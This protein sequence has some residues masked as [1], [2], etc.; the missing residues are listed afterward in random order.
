[1]QPLNRAPLIDLNTP[2]SHS[3]SNI[4]SGRSAKPIQEKEVIPTIQDMTGADN[5]SDAGHLPPNN[6]V[7]LQGRM[8]P[9]SDKTS[10]HHNLSDVHTGSSIKASVPEKVEQSVTQRPSGVQNNAVANPLIQAQTKR[11]K[12]PFPPMAD[13][14][15]NSRGISS[16]SVSDMDVARDTGTIDKSNQMPVAKVSHNQQSKPAVLPSP[17]QDTFTP[18]RPRLRQKSSNQ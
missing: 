14:T 1:M 4:H 9:R 3:I 12:G 18:Q 6:P 17:R 16:Q 2:A 11:L 5:I 10:V 7:Q 15:S 8:L 13:T